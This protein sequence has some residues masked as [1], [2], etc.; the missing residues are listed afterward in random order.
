MA[1]GPSAAEVPAGSEGLLYVHASGPV[2]TGY[3]NL[4]ERNAQAFRETADGRRW[5]AT[6][7]V[8]ISDERGCF[9]YVGRRDRMVKR[10]GYRVELG[11]IEG[12]LYQHPRVKEVAVVAT[13]D[14]EAG[15]RV[16]AF[17]SVRE[18]APPS[19]I[20]MKRFAAERL[21]LYMVPD[22]F[23]WLEALPKTSTDKVDYQKLKAMVEGK[24]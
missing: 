7:D 4:P 12:R 23:A 21:P 16:T 13:P 18:G 14:E 19:L 17:L 6:G 11:E 8:V 3:W 20:E 15:V 9:G 5:Y 2:M 22:R 1:A 24:A 10:R